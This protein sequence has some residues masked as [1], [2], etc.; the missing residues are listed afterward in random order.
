[1]RPGCPALGGPAPAGP[2]SARS[3]A[4][5]PFD[6]ADLRAVLLDLGNVLIKVDFRRVFAAW[7]RS[8]G[9]PAAIIESRWTFD[10][11]YELH[12][13]GEL[14]FA[15]Y[16]AALS[17]RLGFDLPLPAWQAGWNAIFAGVHDRVLATLDEIRQPLFG[18]TNTNATHHEYWRH[19]YAHAVA[20]LQRI[21]VSSELGLRKPHPESFRHVAEH[22]GLAPEQV[23]FLDDTPAHVH[24]ARAAGMRAVHVPSEAAAVAVLERLTVRAT[25]SGTG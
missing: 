13:T 1:M 11:A 3:G 4:G 18:F 2:G 25:D 19:H 5:A 21:Y 16:T 24:G 10:R 6:G 20:P 15:E 17:R 7:S 14:S 9:I 12:E 23:L 22:L 8:A